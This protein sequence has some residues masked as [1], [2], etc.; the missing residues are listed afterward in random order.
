[1]EGRVLCV[2]DDPKI[3]SGYRRALRE[4]Y[5]IE[6]APGGAEA[7][8]AIR[9]GEPFAVVVT[10]M[11]MP[12][13]DGVELLAAVKEASPDT[14]RMMLTGN[15]DIQTA[16]DAANEGA[17]FRFLTKPCAPE[18]LARAL[19]AG[20]AQYRLVMTER[21][22]LQDTLSAT[23][24]VL[25][26]LLSL[27]NPI[28]F[29]RARRIQTLMKQLA[30]KLGEELSWEFEV[31]GVLSQIGCLTL[32]A[33]ILKKVHS[34]KVLDSEEATLF[35]AHPQIGRDLIGHIPRLERVAEIIGCQETRI[36]SQ[37]V[38]LDS[39]GDEPIPLGARAL[40][41]A[42]DFDTLVTAGK[43]DSQALAEMKRAMDWY[44]PDVIAA[45]DDIVTA[46]ITFE[47]RFVDIDDLAPGM[48]LVADIQTESGTCLLN[49]G[50]QEVTATT[51]E[52]LR[53]NRTS[54]KLKEPIEVRIAVVK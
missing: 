18:E 42:L 49:T 9:D 47:T 29:G 1:M 34:G 32:P 22:L 14:V 31:A 44:D 25:G 12:G 23:V 11:R 36:D 52:W 28:A 30:G 45:L 54:L 7:L 3:L 37:G 33:V 16:I 6:T 19:D 43:G 39:S 26:D 5:E 13:M 46:R 35:E 24:K 41:A 2:D 53:H 4:I 10:D 15:A 27:A 48:L 21:Q 20:L 40:H 17:V 50:N 51:K 38:S 8:E